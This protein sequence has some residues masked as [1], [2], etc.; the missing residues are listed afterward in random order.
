[1][2]GVSQLGQVA[3]RTPF[4]T[5][6][7]MNA[8]EDNAARFVPNPFRSDATDLI[9]LSGDRGYYLP[10]GTLQLVGRTDDQLKIW[11]VRVE[12][13]EVAAALSTHEDVRE[14]FV[15]VRA[16]PN[17]APVLVAYVVADNHPAA[18]DLRAHVAS[19][20][21]PA[22]LPAAYVFLDA[23][24]VNANGKIDRDRLPV[25]DLAARGYVAP[26]TPMERDIAEIWRELLGAERVGVEDDFFA[27]GG[28]SLLA[29][30]VASRIRS[31]FGVE[32]PLRT[33]FE[34]PTVGGVAR[35]VVERQLESMSDDD[36]EALLADAR[37]DD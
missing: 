12:P 27:L 18:R 9:Y 7:Y 23:L 20:L 34:Q 14:A 13:G 21:P 4:R 3:I 36:F 15:A 28:H 29:T 25:P 30:R 6:G 17:G 22:A 32:L 11:G 33:L 1:M 35:A 37:Q 2:C 31:A 16:S 5:L 26:R 19:Q 10:D 24:P 8:P